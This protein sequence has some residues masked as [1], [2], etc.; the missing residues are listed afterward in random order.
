MTDAEW[1]ACAAPAPMLQFLLGTTAATIS[2][3]MNTPETWLPHVTDREL[4]RYAVACYRRLLAVLPHPLARA[5]VQVAE[6]TAE[7]FADRETLEQ[8]HASLGRALD[9]FEGHWRA[10]R[11]PAKVAAL[12]VHAALA[13][14][15]QVTHP[16]AGS[17]AWYS[18][19]NASWTAAAMTHPQAA[20]YD[21][22]FLG[23]ETAERRTQAELLRDI[24][25]R[26]SSAG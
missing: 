18:S 7:G 20:S 21:A 25:D 8:A 26:R 1:R 17:A 13:L 12:P 16:D 4:R 2:R 22:A 11:G 5:A 6:R 10:S 24:F 3:G 19:S 23:V 9:D 15:F 14:A